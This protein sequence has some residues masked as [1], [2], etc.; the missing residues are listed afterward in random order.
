MYPIMHRSAILLALCALLAVSALGADLN[1]QAIDEIKAGTRTEAKA[2]WW[3]FDPEDATHALQA[4]IDSGAARVLVEDMG[5]PWIV[6]PI[7]LASNQEVVFEKDVV[8]Q[9]KRGAFKKLGDCLFTCALKENVTLR[10]NGATFEMWKADYHSDAY[11]KSEWRHCLSIRSSSNVNVY[12]LTLADSGGDGIYL[13]VME[14]GVTNK[15]VHIRNVICT[16]NNRQGISVISAEDLLIEN[17]ILEDTGGTAP[18]A[19]IDF[20]PNDP[21]ERLVNCVMRN[22]ITRNNAGDG[23]ELYAMNLDD[24][25]A[26]LSIRIENCQSIADRSCVRV[27]TGNGPPHPAVSGTIEFVNCRFADGQQSGIVIREKPAT[28]AELRFVNC[29]LANPVLGAP[30]LSPILFGSEMRNTENIGGVEFVNLVIQDP[31]GRKPIDYG[32]FSELRLVDV[33]GTLVVEQD[34]KRTPYTLTQELI[35]EWIPAHNFRAIEPFDTQGVRYVPAFDQVEPAALRA[36]PCRQR[37]TATHLAWVEQGDTLTFT[38]SIIPVGSYAVRPASVEITAPSGKKFPLA[39]VE[40]AEPVSYS[41]KAEGS[42]AHTIVCQAGGHTARVGSTTHRLC[43]YSETSLFHFLGTTGEFFLYI[44]PGVSEFAVKVAGASAGE[45]VKASLH[46]PAG[47]LVDEQDN[48]AKARQFVGERTDATQGAVWSLRLSR[49][50]V[51]V[52][53]DFHVQIQGVPPLLGPCPEALFR[54]E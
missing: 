29:V 46:D 45:R 52:L 18:M 32:S 41:F 31:L 5:S 6:E 42:G 25:S 43:A 36:C 17:T 39:D 37:G 54:P 30:S 22:C 53:E 34:G 15:G 27:I 2:S 51:G 4:A 10:G 33:T 23:F 48:I 14:R 28:G 49:P 26:P 1:Q 12:D 11:E 47:T 8:V 24:T 35:D 13:G 9:A 40:G 44:P 7:Q 16:G 3:G 19:G 38:V 20:E 50:A 21:S